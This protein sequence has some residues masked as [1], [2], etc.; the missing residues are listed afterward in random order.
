MKEKIA[1]VEAKV[2]STH[3]LEMFIYESESDRALEE[4]RKNVKQVYS[5]CG[6]SDGDSNIS[7]FSMLVEI[8]FY[9]E[10]ILEKLA[11]IPGEYYI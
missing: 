3:T 1:K 4:L 6:F 2:D 9:Q 10:Q 11:A 7:T 5:E 8:E